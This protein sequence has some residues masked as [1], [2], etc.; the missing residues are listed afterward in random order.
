[1]R[2]KGVTYYVCTVCGYTT[3]NMDFAKCHTCFS[4][5]DKYVAVS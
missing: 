5:K 4:S 2:V 1:M 3:T